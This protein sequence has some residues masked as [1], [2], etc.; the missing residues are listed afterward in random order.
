[1]VGPLPVPHAVSV[2]ARI[3]SHLEFSYR[4]GI[5][6]NY[7]VRRASAASDRQETS[8]LGPSATVPP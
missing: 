7:A 3:W 1:M 2:D 8:L 5:V 6:L 4:F